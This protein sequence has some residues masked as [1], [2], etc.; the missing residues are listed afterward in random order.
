MAYIWTQDQVIPQETA[1]AACESLDEEVDQ[2]REKGALKAGTASSVRL[3]WTTQARKVAE[4]FKT[5]FKESTD[6]AL[7]IQ[8]LGGNPSGKL[9]IGSP[10]VYTDV[11]ST[12]LRYPSSALFYGIM[13]IIALGPLDLPDVGDSRSTRIESGS[14]AY[15]R[16]ASPIEY[17][18]CK[19]RGI[20][21]RISY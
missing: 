5:A 10:F 20:M 15:F 1:D 6:V 18:K 17:R 13:G 2:K 11:S 19:G 3:G 4:V 7:M 9:V 8:N 21:F 16:D 12:P 14:V